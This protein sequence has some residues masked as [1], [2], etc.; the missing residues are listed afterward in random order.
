MAAG[1]P[2][3][4]R[5]CSW[6]VQLPHDGVALVP[7]RGPGDRGAEVVLSVLACE[8]VQVGLVALQAEH[9][10]AAERGHELSVLAGAQAGVAGGDAELHVSCSQTL[11][12]SSRNASAP[13]VCTEEPSPS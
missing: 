13:N 12:S 6:G 1:S 9:V 7:L 4:S 2:A 11:G 10:P 3:T 5:A 8:V